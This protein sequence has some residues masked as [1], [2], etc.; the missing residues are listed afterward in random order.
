MTK[1]YELTDETRK[2]REHTLHRIRALRDFSDVK[3]GDLGGWVESEYNLSQDGNC[4]VYDDA[5]VH[6]NAE[7][8]NNAIVRDYAEVCDYAKVFD[9]AKLY[10]DAMV[11]GYARVY[12]YAEV[13]DGFVD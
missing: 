11:Q 7:V 13:R 1:K 9:S 10:N 4:W 6:G 8:F 2:F 5:T 12:G 3:A